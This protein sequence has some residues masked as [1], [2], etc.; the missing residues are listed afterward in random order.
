MFNKVMAHKIGA[1]LYLLWGVL[2]IKAAIATA[3][4]GDWSIDKLRS[5][6]D[7]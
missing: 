1:V 6:K 5:D 4:G 7:M 2:H 3:G